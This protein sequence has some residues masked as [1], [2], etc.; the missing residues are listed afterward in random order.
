MMCLVSFVV[1]ITMFVNFSGLVSFYVTT[2]LY[3]KYY[4]TSA[5]T[6][7]IHMFNAAT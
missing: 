4:S 7:L 2:A 1:T 5:Y 6:R 3:L